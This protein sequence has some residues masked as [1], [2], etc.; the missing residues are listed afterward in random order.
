MT[1]EINVRTEILHAL[2]A[3]DDP[4][5]RAMLALLGRVL[6]RM[7]HL[8]TDV[9][10]AEKVRLLALN[11]EAPFHAE[12]HEMISDLRA[13][14]AV[15]AVRWVTARMEHDGYC[16]FANRIMAEE[17]TRKEA[18]KGFWSAARTAFAAKLAEL[19][20]T[21]TAAVAAAIWATK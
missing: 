16:D 15:Q 8:L 10:N 9:M 14:N 7:E 4:K 21:V 11:G 12:D 5:D 19:A 2:T 1:D 20:V 3:S 17:A 13:A 6:D 18:K